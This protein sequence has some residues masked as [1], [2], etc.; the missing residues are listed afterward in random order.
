M[1]ESEGND[2]NDDEDAQMFKWKIY[3][4][5]DDVNFS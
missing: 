4:N 5:E 2:D 3:S 1:D